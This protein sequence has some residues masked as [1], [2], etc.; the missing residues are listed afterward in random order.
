MSE[1]TAP[2]R[3]GFTR[4]VAPSKWADRWGRAVPER[5][6]ELVPISQQFGRSGSEEAR[7]CD[8]LI[9]R[10]V[11][12]ERPLTHTPDGVRTHHAMLLYEE[13]IALVLPKDHELAKEAAIHIDD[14][15]L[16]KLLDYPGHAPDWPAAEPWV[17]QSWEPRGLAAA[18]ELVA[19]G[20]GG[21]LVP[22]PLAQHVANKREHAILRVVGDSPESLPL[23][24]STVWATWAAEHNSEDLQQLA[25]IMRGRT[26]RSSRRAQEKPESPSA[27]KPQSQQQAQQQAKKKKPA[28]KPNSRGAQLAAVREKAARNKAIRAAAKRKKR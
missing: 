4:G 25:G 21:I 8:M 13:A 16:V 17:D 20:L 11:P 9:E 24:G 14:L 6:L 10:A 3:L 28:L 27:K 26:A 2:I 7:S 5:A 1:H 22:L 19:T 15:S 23:R 18:L 12:G